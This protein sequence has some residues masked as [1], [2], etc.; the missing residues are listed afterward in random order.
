MKIRSGFVT[1]SSSSSFIFYV[2]IKKKNSETVK[3]ECDGIFGSH[4]FVSPKEL[5]MAKTVDQ[6]IEMVKE[7][8]FSDSTKEYPIIN[9]SDLD[10]FKEIRSMDEIASVTV[11]G[12]EYMYRYEQFTEYTYDLATGEYTG[13]IYGDDVPSD[14]RRNGLHFKDADN[15]TLVQSEL[16]TPPED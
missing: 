9:L 1:N 14:A 8:A 15:V 11:G 13:V 12:L 10:R 2:K 6:L 4:I 3:V 5:A 16:N 7:N